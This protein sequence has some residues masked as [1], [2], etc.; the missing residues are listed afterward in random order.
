VFAAVEGDSAQE[1]SRG[2]RHN[3]PEETSEEFHASTS[4]LTWP[5][6]RKRT[7]GEALDAG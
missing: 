3:D 7:A 5:V 2:E 4:L 6:L 1:K